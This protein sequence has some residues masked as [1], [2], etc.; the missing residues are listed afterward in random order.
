MRLVL[1]LSLFL[2]SLLVSDG[3]GFIPRQSSHEAI[4]LLSTFVWPRLPR[5]ALKVLGVWTADRQVPRCLFFISWEQ[6]LNFPL[7]MNSSSTIQEFLKLN[8]D[9][10]T[11]FRP[12]ELR[13]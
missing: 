10:L 8:K 12:L 7:K 11:A 1:V 6:E 13:E 5:H 9:T 2:R 4:L 3:A